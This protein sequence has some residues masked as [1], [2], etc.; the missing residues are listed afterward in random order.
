MNSAWKSPQLKPI[1]NKIGASF[2]YLNLHISWNSLASV[3]ELEILMQ[4]SISDGVTS[5]GEII[6]SGK[7][8]LLY[9]KVEVEACSPWQDFKALVILFPTGLGF[10]TSK[11]KADDNSTRNISSCS[12]L[13]ASEPCWTACWELCVAEEI[14]TS[15]ASAL[16]SPCSGRAPSSWY[17][18]DPERQKFGRACRSVSPSSE[19]YMQVFSL[20]C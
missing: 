15:I 16:D 1:L 17:R 3:S 14:S 8:L 6:T 5:S 9:N 7:L 4:M 2:K 10:C 12:M 18:L 19:N 11:N 20:F 13:F